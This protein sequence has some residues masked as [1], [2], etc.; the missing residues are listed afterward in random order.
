MAPDTQKVLNKHR[1]MNE[2]VTSPNSLLPISRRAKLTRRPHSGL[3]TFR[4]PL[5]ARLCEHS[6]SIPQPCGTHKFLSL[7]LCAEPGLQFHLS[8]KAFL[9]FFCCPRCCFFQFLP[10][11]NPTHRKAGNVRVQVNLEREMVTLKHRRESRHP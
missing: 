6:S 4:P 3:R 9:L 10:N 7:Q 1:W 2:H 5:P 8:L 11:Q